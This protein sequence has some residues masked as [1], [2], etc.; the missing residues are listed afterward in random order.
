MRLT[1]NLSAQADLGLG[2]ERHLALSKVD[3]ELKVR[4][5]ESTTNNRL[6]FGSHTIHEFALDL[7]RYNRAQFVAQLVI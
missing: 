3:L 4:I 7:Y 5:L 2:G 6:A 1:G